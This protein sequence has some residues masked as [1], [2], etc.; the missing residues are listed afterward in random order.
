MQGKI[1]TLANWWEVKSQLEERLGN[2]WAAREAITLAVE[3]RRQ[4]RSAS[5]LLAL[6]HALEKLG[7]LSR[8][9]GD[10]EGEERAR[11][12]AK[13]IREELNLIDS[14]KAFL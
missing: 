4:T 5:A 1:W 11:S 13:S 12:E 14:R 7:N 10:E 3:N 2:L 6:A 9:A 8:Q